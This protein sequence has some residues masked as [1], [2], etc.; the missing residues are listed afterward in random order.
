MAARTNMQGLLGNKALILGK[1]DKRDG[2]K[3]QGGLKTGH[4]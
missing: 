3:T 1:L 4:L 2:E